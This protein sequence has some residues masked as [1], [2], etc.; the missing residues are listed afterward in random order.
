[1]AFNAGETVYIRPHQA[2]EKEM[3][4]ENCGLPWIL[5]MNDGEYGFGV[6]YSIDHIR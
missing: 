4:M 2:H 1:M 6:T 5:D 3:Y